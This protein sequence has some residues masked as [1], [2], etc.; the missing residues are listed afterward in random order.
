MFFL[1]HNSFILSKRSN[2][3]VIFIRYFMQDEHSNYL[4]PTPFVQPNLSRDDRCHLILTPGQPIW[5][6]KLCPADP[7][8]H[9]TTK[10]TNNTLNIITCVRAN[11]IHH[12][13]TV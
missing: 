13:V 11:T 12:N 1:A 6:H 7:K 8:D 5:L 3:Q 4:P 10:S 2:L 9:I